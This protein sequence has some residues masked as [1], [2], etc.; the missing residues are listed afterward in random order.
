MRRTEESDDEQD[1]QGEE[2]PAVGEE[3]EQGNLM[4]SAEWEAERQND[5]CKRQNAKW[6]T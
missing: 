1:R 5:Q 4:R 3:A 6:G 2:E